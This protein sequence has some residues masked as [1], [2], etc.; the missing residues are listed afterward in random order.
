MRKKFSELTP[1]ENL[2]VKEDY[3]WRKDSRADQSHAAEEVSDAQAEAL[4]NDPDY[5][6]RAEFIHAMFVAYKEYPYGVSLVGKFIDMP[7]GTRVF[8][9][10]REKKK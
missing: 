10:V 4:Y 5:P 9:F 1:E 2:E 3:I 7:D 6:T 8:K